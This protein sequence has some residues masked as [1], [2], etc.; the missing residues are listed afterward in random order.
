MHLQFVTYRAG[1]M[2]DR[3]FIDANQEFAAAMAEVPGLLAKL[4]L[5][6]PNGGVYGGVYLWRDRA[7]F[8]AFVA[9]ELWSSVLDDESIA[10]LDSR[11]FETMQELTSATQPGLKIV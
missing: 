6:D 2:T 11:D 10:E 7:A 8:E 4:W 1:E 9:G 5:K 3:E